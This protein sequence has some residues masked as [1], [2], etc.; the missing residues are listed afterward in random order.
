MFEGL[1]LNN[2][3]R[4]QHVLLP[5]PSGSQFWPSLV[6]VP[7]LIWFGPT[8]D[9][10]SSLGAESGEEY[11]SLS[12]FR[13]MSWRVWVF[14]LVEFW[15]SHRNPAAE[16]AFCSLQILVG[17]VFIAMPVAL[18]K[19][20]PVRASHGIAAGILSGLFG[21]SIGIDGPPIFCFSQPT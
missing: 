13:I 3:A 10:H 7:M 19:K 15:V 14:W 2:T 4:S 11:R 9:F 6:S 21:G 12:R 16:G 17:L 18:G 20:G 1:T 5:M 8:R